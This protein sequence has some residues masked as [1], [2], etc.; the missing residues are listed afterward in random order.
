M[1]NRYLIRLSKKEGNRDA[2]AFWN[3]GGAQEYARA[4]GTREKET[5]AKPTM[6]EK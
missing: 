5:N 6:Q 4:L 3:A 2:R 1:K